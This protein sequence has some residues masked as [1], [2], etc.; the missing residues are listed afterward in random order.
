MGII[1]S[2]TAELGDLSRGAELSRPLGG[3]VYSDINTKNVFFK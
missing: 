3:K 1:K 2:P